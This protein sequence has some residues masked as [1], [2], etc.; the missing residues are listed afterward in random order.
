MIADVSLPLRLLKEYRKLSMRK[1]RNKNGKMILEGNQL[2]EEAL[3]AGVTL[4]SL[5]YT[6]QFA[7]KPGA[8][9]NNKD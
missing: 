4:E 6:A 9:I 1:F 3:S 7:S 8:G 5:I 2:L